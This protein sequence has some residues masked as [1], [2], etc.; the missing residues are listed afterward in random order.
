M[1][2]PAGSA[3][4]RAFTDLKRHDMGSGLREPIADDG[5]D[6]QTWMT[7]S[8]WGVGATGPWLHDGRATTLMSA[9]LEHGG[10]AEAARTAVRG[11]S[12][13]SQRDL[14]AF[15]DNLTLGMFDNPTGGTGG[16]TGAG[17]R[18][19]RGARPAPG[20]RAGPPVRT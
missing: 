11:L 19:A 10:E 8:L 9:I 18:P 12:V 6:N 2:A 4:V 15:L 20:A 3:I 5:V 14:V 1:G 16:T 17:A 7:R 13:Q